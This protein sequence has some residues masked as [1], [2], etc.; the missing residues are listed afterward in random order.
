[1]PSLLP[2]D[3][4]RCQHELWQ[5]LDRFD[6]TGNNAITFEEF[7]RL[8]LRKARTK[9]VLRAASCIGSYWLRSRSHCTFLGKLM[10]EHTAAKKSAEAEKLRNWAW[11]K[12][13]MCHKLGCS[14]LS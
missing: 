3:R 5:A 4:K 14:P 2:L 7:S 8:K 6:V 12:L 13:R 1:M 11:K 10:R 9:H